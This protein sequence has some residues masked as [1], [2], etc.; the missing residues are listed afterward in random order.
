MEVP[1]NETPEPVKSLFDSVTGLLAAYGWSILFF[2]VIANLLWS[3]FYPKY[4]KWREK[5]EDQEKEAEYEQNPDLIIS[6]QE[7]LALARQRLQEQHD[8]LAREYAEKMKEKEEKKR[9][10]KIEAYERMMQGKSKSVQPQTL[11]GSDYN[12]L[13]GSGGGSCSYRPARQRGGG[14]GG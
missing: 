12:P 5:V 11:R 14:G 8:R 4:K 2:L 1:P 3:H 9:K 10:E 7:A 6:R 13:T